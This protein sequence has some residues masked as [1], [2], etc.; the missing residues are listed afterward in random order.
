MNWERY[1]GVRGLDEDTIQ[2]F[3]WGTEENHKNLSQDS[4][5]P[6]RDLNSRP[7]EY[8]GGGFV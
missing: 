5:S 3:A 2:A 1:S 7:L 6:R 4:L 8:E